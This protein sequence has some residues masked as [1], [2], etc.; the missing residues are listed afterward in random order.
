MLRAII[1]IGSSLFFASGADAGGTLALN[2]VWSRMADLNGE[3][4]SVES[5]EFASDSRFIATGSKFDNTVRIFR[6]SDG[7][8]LWERT[9][10]QEIER[11]AWTRD[12][13]HVVS[14]SEDALMRVFD[15]STGEVVFTFQ[16]DNGIDGLSVSHDGKYLVTGQERV[17]GVGLVRVFSTADW[18]LLKSIEHPGTVNGIDFSS[19][20][21][22]LAVIGDYDARI[23][24]VSNWSV[25]H[26]WTLARGDSFFGADPHI[27]ISARFS[28]DDAVLAVGASHGFVYL[29]DAASAK[30]IRRLN[31]TGQKTEIVEW[32]KDGRFLLV[33]GHGDSIDFY[34]VSKLLDAKIQNDSVPFALRAKVSDSMEYLD[35]NS[36]GAMLVSAHQDG[37][38]QLWT[39]MSDDPNTNERRHREV[40]RAQDEAAKAAGRFVE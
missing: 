12:G 3:L 17:R 35:F 22:H 11:V 25:R 21:A 1:V 34:D 5:A 6:T 39:Y 2:Q 20:D 7:H 10:P 38:V 24:R 28:A 37:T 26:Q 40:R 8:Q 14:V 31:K 18:R 33:A 32:T 9:L 23:Y 15:V 29:Y 27:Y 30:L 36:S 19:D 16:H 4:G 13:R